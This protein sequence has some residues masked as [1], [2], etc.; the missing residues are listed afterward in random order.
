MLGLL[1]SAPGWRKAPGAPGAPQNW[2]PA[3]LSRGHCL[4]LGRGDRMGAGL[5][6]L[7]ARGLRGRVWGRE[8]DSRAAPVG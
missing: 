5:A 4:S 7:P 1:T 6:Q 8:C 3:P 2:H